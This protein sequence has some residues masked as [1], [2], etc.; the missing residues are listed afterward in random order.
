MTRHGEGRASPVA[1]FRAL[2][3]TQSSGLGAFGTVRYLFSG[4]EVW[5]QPLPSAPD[6]IIELYWVG[7]LQPGHGEGSAGM[8][9]LADLADRTGVELLL[10][11]DP[12]GR[13]GRMGRDALRR[14][15]ER[16]GFEATSGHLVAYWPRRRGLEMR[17]SPR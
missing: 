4:L 10:H 13:R 7:A 12:W 16:F 5:L 17:R 8:R 1:H 2:A 6:T 3:R 9:A 15:Y 11:A 14:W